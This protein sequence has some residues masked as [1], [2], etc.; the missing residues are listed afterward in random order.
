MGRDKKDIVAVDIIRLR[1][2]LAKAE[3]ANKR[4][5]YDAVLDALCEVAGLTM[6]LATLVNGEKVETNDD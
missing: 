5:D 2:K 3:E 4:G 6:S 1:A